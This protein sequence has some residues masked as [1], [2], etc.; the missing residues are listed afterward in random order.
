MSH[1]IDQDFLNKLYNFN[2]TPNFN[3]IYA[4]IYDTIKNNNVSNIIQLFLN[5]MNIIDTKASIRLLKSII[6][7]YTY[8]SIN[9][10]NINDIINE[11]II[12]FVINN[13]L[14]EYRFNN[15]ISLNY[16]EI[17]CYTNININNSIIN[18]IDISIIEK[19]NKDSICLL[20]KFEYSNQIE[21]L[22][23]INKIY[24]IVY[25]INFINKYN[26]DKS[27]NYHIL[28]MKLLIFLLYINKVSYILNSFNDKIQTLIK[29][30]ENTAN[31]ILEILQ[32]WKTDNTYKPL[33][34]EQNLII[35]FTSMCCGKDI[36]TYFNND[37]TEM[38]DKVIE[39]VTEFQ[40]NIPL[41]MSHKSPLN[42]Y[43]KCNIIEFNGNSK[44]WDYKINLISL[45]H[46]FIELEKYNESMGFDSRDKIRY[47]ILCIIYK[48]LQIESNTFKFKEIIETDNLSWYKF[49]ILL[50]SFY[51]KVYSSYIKNISSKYNTIDDI[52]QIDIYSFKLIVSSMM[53]INNI[54]ISNLSLVNN[55][56]KT[57]WINY[58]THDIIIWWSNN[59]KLWIDDKVKNIIDDL[60]VNRDRYSDLYNDIKLLFDDFIKKSI[61]IDT[62]I[63]MKYAKDIYD[64]KV[65]RNF[66]DLDI[67]YNSIQNEIFLEK[68]IKLVENTTNNREIPNEFLD[69]IIFELIE[70]PIELPETHT[71]VDEKVICKHLILKCEN[72]VNRSY[73]S[74]EDLFNYQEKEDVKER[75]RVWKHKYITWLRNI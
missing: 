70:N 45:I 24:F 59:I 64:T 10:I 55:I 33:L 37:I 36:L 50:N 5:T 35:E 18:E 72:P 42:I 30:I 31:W 75:L 48:N 23:F 40:N 28:Y 56:Q 60:Y 4:H 3:G 15:V 9:N 58:I 11:S 32:E 7:K 39:L 17:L 47:L 73:L 29:Y 8:N 65:I 34:D 68:F 62:T 69:P 41:W 16:Y 19:Y 51:Y 57:K 67:I 26:I 12:K 2:T 14:I 25:H 46:L 74:I 49:S 38:P 44:F 27:N 71:I 21:D 52:N 13:N 54:I 43:T 20:N 6:G 1:P 61:N 66:V 22:S 53:L 63:W